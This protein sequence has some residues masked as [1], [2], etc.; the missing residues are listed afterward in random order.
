MARNRYVLP[1]FATRHQVPVGFPTPVGATWHWSLIPTLVPTLQSDALHI[2]SFRII[3]RY[4]P[5]FSVGNWHGVTA[6]YQKD[7]LPAGTIH[8]VRRQIE[9]H[10]LVRFSGIQR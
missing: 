10:L 2:D 5:P 1:D 4:L 7:G 3:Y 9:P 8:G 6:N